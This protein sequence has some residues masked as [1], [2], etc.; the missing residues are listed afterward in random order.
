MLGTSGGCDKTRWQT[1]FVMSRPCLFL[2]PTSLAFTSGAV[3]VTGGAR[4]CF[5]NMRTCSLWVVCPSTPIP[6]ICNHHHSA[7]ARPSQ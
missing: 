7:G 4:A 2:A 5:V 6:P 1:H 3:K